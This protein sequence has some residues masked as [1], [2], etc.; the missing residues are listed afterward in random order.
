MHLDDERIQ[1]LLHGGLEPPAERE[2]RRHLES[3]AGCR[4]LLEEARAE[5]AWIFAVLG[6]VDHPPPAVD[7]GTLLARAE[8]VSPRWFGRAAVLLLGIGLAGV[9]Y[10]APGSPLPAVLNRLLG[11]TP[12]RREQSPAA[13]AAAATPAQAGIAVLPG[14]ALVIQFASEGDAV[15]T[16]SLTDD[17]EVVVR[18]VE[19]SA[20]FTSAVDRLV[21]RS[22]G[23]ARFEILIPRR[24]PSVDVLADT[25]PVFRKP[26]GGPVSAVSP[27]ALGR[28]TVPLQSPQP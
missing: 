18:A 12:D 15:A 23:R 5:E 25:T 21:V 1:R 27:D 17:E 26:A 13:Q 6:S 24:A 8:R 22:A 4:G 16:I 19:G 20:S 9:A 3:C 10:A 28:Y 2:A 14:D 7:P 11:N